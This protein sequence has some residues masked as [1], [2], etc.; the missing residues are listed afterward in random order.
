M[1]H[2]R[3]D[4]ILLLQIWLQYNIVIILLKI[5]IEKYHNGHSYASC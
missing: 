5:L 3:D 2:K 1:G 4:A